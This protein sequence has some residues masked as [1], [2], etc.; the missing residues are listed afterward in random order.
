MWDITLKILEQ[1]SKGGLN[2][3]L[4]PRKV[5]ST[6]L[7]IAFEEYIH[8]IAKFWMILNRFFNCLKNYAKLGIFLLLMT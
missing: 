3:N 5:R 1:I 8:K 4:S 2:H 7:C 6:L